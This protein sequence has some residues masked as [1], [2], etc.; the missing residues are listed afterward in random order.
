MIFAVG[1]IFCFAS[2]CFIISSTL[3]VL[4]HT[5]VLGTCTGMIIILIRLL[6][7]KDLHKYEKLGAFFIIIGMA[8]LM[9]D[10]RARK[11]DGKEASLWGE[12]FGFM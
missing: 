2:T 10:G 11:G 12:F 6:T 8:V 1:C 9:S 4:S 7:C 3:T 5:Q